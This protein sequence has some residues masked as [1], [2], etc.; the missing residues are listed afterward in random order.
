MC[1]IVKHANIIRSDNYLEYFMTDNNVLI[2]HLINIL[3]IDYNF[4]WPSA[5]IL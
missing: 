5:L 2:M 3:L 4:L 1:E